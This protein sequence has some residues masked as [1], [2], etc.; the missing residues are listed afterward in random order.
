MNATYRYSLPFAVAL[1]ALLPMGASAGSV[2]L[3]NVQVSG[4]QID[5]L[6]DQAVPQR[7]VKTEFTRNI[8]QIS[9]KNASVYPAKVLSVR[10][11]DV[12]R[13]FAYQYTPESVRVRLTV[14]GEA[15]GYE[16]GTQVR[17]NGKLLTI[18][19]PR[20]KGSATA[21]SA[22]SARQ[23]AQPLSAPTPEL[24]DRDRAKLLG[25]V[26]ASGEN[27]L[28]LGRPERAVPA[29]P[30]AG[31][32]PMPSPFKA[33]GWL[34]VLLGAIGLLAVVFRKFSGKVR[35]PKS[36]ARMAAR[37]DFEVISSQSLGP[38]RNLMLVRV[39]NRLLVL[40][41]AN[42]AI[43]LITEFHDDGTLPPPSRGDGAMAAGPAAFA[44]LLQSEV[45]QQGARAPAVSLNRATTLKDPVRVVDEDL[46]PA[47]P[48][49]PAR[50]K[51][52][53]PSV[54]DSIRRRVE[55]MKTL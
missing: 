15:A 10:D 53:E 39:K 26:M 28:P 55:G 47:V 50:V 46:T 21:I 3:R 24:S 18:Q 4:N 14:E 13:V 49:R 7:D 30:L 34:A 40:G 54:R 6:F 37:K 44:D 27:E 45:F 23:P 9:V 31:G 42:D 2:T 33:F 38:R 35:L 43:N 11:A 12:S 20:R 32:K 25:K 41:C 36:L 17:M 1:F 5:L 8:V 48:T 29:Q 22:Q 19:I 51:V 52:A 16:Q